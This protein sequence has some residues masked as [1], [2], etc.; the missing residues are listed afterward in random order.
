MG[1]EDTRLIETRKLYSVFIALQF[2]ENAV[3]NT[4]CCLTE[5]IAWKHSVDVRIVHRPETL[6]NIHGI[7]VHAGYNKYF[8]VL[9]DLPL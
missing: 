7:V 2:A 3:S 4:L 9:S 5:C 8:S 6:T 1:Q